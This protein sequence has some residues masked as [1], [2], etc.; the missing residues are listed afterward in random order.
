MPSVA[1]IIQPLNGIQTVYHHETGPTDINKEITSPN[2]ERLIIHDSQGYN[3][4]TAKIF[5]DLQEF[6]TE[7]NQKDSTAER[8][9]A[10]W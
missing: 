5:D 10:I 2:D 4:G 6:I 7:R 3:P 8:L 1:V 9:D